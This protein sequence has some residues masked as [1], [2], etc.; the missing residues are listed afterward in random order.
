MVLQSG[1]CLLLLIPSAAALG[2]IPPSEAYDRWSADKKV[3]YFKNVLDIGHGGSKE[4]AN[5]I[6]EMPEK[7]KCMKPECVH[8]GGRNTRKDLVNPFE[9]K[10]KGLHPTGLVAFVRAEWEENSYTGMFQ[11]A[12]FGYVRWGFQFYDWKMYQME[13]SGKAV[14]E[15][16]E[17]DPMPEGSDPS[18]WHDLDC[19]KYD[20]FNVSQEFKYNGS[21]LLENERPQ[22]AQFMALKFFRDDVPS[23]AIHTGSVDPPTWNHL[24]HTYTNFIM[25]L[26]EEVNDTKAGSMTEQGAERGTRWP[27]F[28]GLHDMAMFDQKGMLQHDINFPYQIIFRPRSPEVIP[29][30]M[31]GRIQESVEIAR[32]KLTPGTLLYDIYAKHDFASAPVLLGRI[33]LESSIMA[34]EDTDRQVFF[35]HPRYDRDLILR[36]ELTQGHHCKSWWICPVCPLAEE[37]CAPSQDL[38]GLWDYVQWNSSQYGQGLETPLTS[39]QRPRVAPH[40]PK[41]LKD[42]LTGGLQLF[43]GAA[44]EAPKRRRWTCGYA[45]DMEPFPAEMESTAQALPEPTEP[46]LLRRAKRLQQPPRATELALEE[47]K[48]GGNETMMRGDDLLVE[49]RSGLVHTSKWFCNGEKARWPNKQR[50]KQQSKC[51]S[52]MVPGR[53][54]SEPEYQLEEGCEDLPQCNKFDGTWYSTTYPCQ[55]GFSVCFT[56]QLC[57]RASNSCVSWG[58]YAKK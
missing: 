28:T 6:G 36:P 24:G 48:D 35:Y 44:A 56:G 54:V 33:F 17:L 10:M 53:P 51:T 18:A 1:S 12:D 9:C 43:R 32:E 21:E 47:E 2:F 50:V 45:Q 30:S 46:L 15:G 42:Y 25:N 26:G 29:E 4:P 23:A 58:P 13:Q 7:E 49:P 52:T 22:P 37:F 57:F 16:K 20:C 8:P 27:G 34:S 39:M 14:Y 31:H 11:K 40:G 5:W 55:C 19:H 38:L 41:Q 3:A